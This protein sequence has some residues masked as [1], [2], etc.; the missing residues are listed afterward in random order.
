MRLLTECVDTG[1]MACPGSSWEIITFPVSKSSML[2]G[3][4]NHFGESSGLQHEILNT[5]C[6][7]NTSAC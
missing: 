1:L 7:L 6:M 5:K 2:F 3:C 4:I